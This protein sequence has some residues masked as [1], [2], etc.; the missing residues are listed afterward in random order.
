MN[1]RSRSELD[2][3]L[4]HALAEI[5][6]EW[7]A[8]SSFRALWPTRDIDHYLFFSTYGAPKRFL[9][10]DFGLRNPAAEDFAMTAI[11]SYGGELYRHLKRSL[12]VDCTMQFSLGRLVGWPSR[13]SLDMDAFEGKA[14][15]DRV[16]DDIRKHLFPV[17]KPITGP[18]ELLAILLADTAPF[19]WVYTNG[20]IRA[21]EIVS[22][23]RQ[24]EVADKQICEALRPRKKWIDA[25]LAKGRISV[26]E[27]LE[28]ILL[29]VPGTAGVRGKHKG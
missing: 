16:R 9:A 23:G 7:I 10:A 3:G 13:S 15:F 18:A 17:V 19:E 6:Y 1:R 21:A 14:L 28:K 22:L 25:A 20:A 24:K 12:P 8:P 11:A 26:E 5:G 2:V 4:D 29:R 27:Y